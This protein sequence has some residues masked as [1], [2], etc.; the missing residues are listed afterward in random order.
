[1]S[2]TVPVLPQLDLMSFAQFEAGRLTQNHAGRY[3]DAPS[4]AEVSVKAVWTIRRQLDLEA[5]VH[6]LF[7]ANYWIADGY[8]E[9]GRTVL[10]GARWKF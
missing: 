4:F 1:V 5:S 3:M 7:D 6:N 9:P 2:A 8:P 10:V